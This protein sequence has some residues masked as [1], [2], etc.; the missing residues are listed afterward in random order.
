M[1]MDKTERLSGIVDAL[2]QY[3]EIVRG[4]DLDGT[5]TLLGM[6][7]LDLQMHIHDISDEELQ[8]LCD[9]VEA[10]QQTCA[11]VASRSESTH[12]HANLVLPTSRVSERILIDA[13]RPSKRWKRM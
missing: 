1:P 8:A 10:G 12:S 9:V 6:A 4:Y 3:I 7:K 5:A 13:P 11:P 2:N